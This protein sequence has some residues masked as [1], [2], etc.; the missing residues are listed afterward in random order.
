MPNPQLCRLIVPAGW[1]GLTDD[2]RRESASWKH[3]PR[4]ASFQLAITLRTGERS[5]LVRTRSSGALLRF[6]ASEDL[7]QS[8]L[9]FYQSRF[10]RRAKVGATVLAFLN[11]DGLQ[12]VFKISL[13]LRDLCCHHYRS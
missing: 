9:S 1:H 3:T 6:V 10:R 5:F 8:R 13:E 7:S 4:D 2:G 11:E 12:R